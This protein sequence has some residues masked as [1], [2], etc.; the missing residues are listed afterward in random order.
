MHILLLEDDLELGAELQRALAGAGL[1]SVW[2]RRARDAL[3]QIASNAQ[4]GFSCALVDLGLPD[5][6]GMDVLRT[7]RLQGCALPTIIL[8]ARDALSSRLSGLDTGAD[9]YVIKPVAVEELVSRIHAVTRRSA[10][11]AASLWQVG[12]LLI[13]SRQFQVRIDG[14][15]IDLSPKE[16]LVITELARNPEAVVP[17]HR[18]AAVL[19]PVGD[20]VELNALEVHIHNLR[21]K[22][23]PE[24]I[25]TIRGVGYRLTST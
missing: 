21:R 23:G 12:R 13:D 17:K 4:P 14:E 1:T 18:L 5:G 9:D 7:W 24:V 20:P 15:V 16:H 22:L 11:H 3:A 6:E 19:T 25:Q 2:V 8:T 10:G